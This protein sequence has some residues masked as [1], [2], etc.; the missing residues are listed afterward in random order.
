MGA[1]PAPAVPPPYRPPNWDSPRFRVQLKMAKSRIEIQRGK[2]DNEITAMRR[3]IATHLREKKDPLARIQCERVLR[4]RSQVIAYDIVDTCIEMLASSDNMFMNSNNFD[5]IAHDV[6][7]AVASTVFASSRINVPELV[8]V[9]NMLRNHFGAHIIDPIVQMDG[10]NIK[11]INKLLAQQLSGNPPDGH[12][13]LKELSKIASEHGVNGWEAPAEENDLSVL[14]QHG[15]GGGNDF[16]HPPYGP[17]GGPPPPYGPPGGPG[18]MGP[19][20]GGGGGGGGAYYNPSAPDPSVLNS[21]K[22]SPPSN[23][24]GQSHGGPPFGMQPSAPPFNPSGS[25]TGSFY[26]PS[27]NP[28]G[29]RQIDDQLHSKFDRMTRKDVN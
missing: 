11:F 20:F 14:Y 24:P 28:E 17:P 21:S 7:L 5:T 29:M 10:P 18:D 15:H 19:G 23:I 4:E 13:I 8:P 12:L 27:D 25:V 16:N 2:K 6:K 9:T 3:T 1:A 22:F 26:P